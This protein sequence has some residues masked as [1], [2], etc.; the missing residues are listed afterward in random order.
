M[1]DTLLLELDAR[2]VARLTLNRPE[3]HNTLSA[4]MIEEL[5]AVAARLGADPAVRV[6]V[7]AAIGESFCAG[8]DLTWMKA[9]IAGDACSGNPANF[10]GHLLNSDHERKAQHESPCETVA[11]LRANLISIA[12]WILKECDRIRKRQSTNFQGIIDVTTII[13]DGLK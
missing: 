7:L 11:E 4:R 9:Q 13:R 5:T 10:G 1:Y 2:G 12:I 8:G 6:V 3:K